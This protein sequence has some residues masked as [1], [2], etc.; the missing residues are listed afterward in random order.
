MSSSFFEFSDAENMS[1]QPV[2][3]DRTMDLVSTRT[4]SGPHSAVSIKADND[5]CVDYEILVKENYFKRDDQLRYCRT[6]GSG[7]QGKVFLIEQLGEDNFVLPVAIKFFSPYKYK[8]TDDY[9]AAMRQM[10]AVAMKVCRI[11]H[12]N[13]VDVRNWWANR[14]IR[15]MEMEWIDGYDLSVLLNL[16]SLENIE[17]KIKN[18]KRLN[19]MNRI[20][21][22]RGE[23]SAKVK[24]GVAVGI[25]R[26]CLAGLAALHRHG[27]VHGDIKPGNIM[28]KRTGS[29]K[30]I[31]INSARDMSVPASSL[32]YTPLYAAPEVVLDQTFSPQSD[33]ASLGYVLLEMLAGRSP[34]YGTKTID[35]QLKI[36]RE[37]G[38]RIRDYLPEDVAM[39]DDLVSFCLGLIHPDPAKRYSDAEAADLT[40]NGAASFLRGLVR[41]E[42]S[43]EYS[44]EIRLWVEEMPVIFTPSEHRP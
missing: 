2:D 36:K 30:I 13:L 17:K 14:N 28:L 37:L 21:V 20:T 16:R 18:E 22:T 33:L 15:V 24:P 11:Q 42:L 19:D 5:Y 7:G 6:L 23:V 43:C 9:I 35:D 32:S 1:K 8:T 39:S 31:D 29:A 41:G 34:F 40:R 44:N 10:A 25:V 4:W 12:D 26:E 3:A 38:D 27:I